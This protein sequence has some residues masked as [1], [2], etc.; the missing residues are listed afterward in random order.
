MLHRRTFLAAAAA[1]LAAPR[2]TFAAETVEALVVADVATRAILLRQGA[3]DR[4]FTP[5]STFK[6]PLALIG[7]D[8]GIL[9][10]AHHPAWEYRPELQAPERDRKTVDP[11]VWL[12]DSVVW[13]SQEITRKLG[14]EDFRRYVDLLG[15]GNRNLSG[16][17][18]LTR[19]WLDSSLAL[20]PE[21]QVGFVLGL[22][23]RDFPV[24]E[25]AYAMTGASMP[26]FEAEGGWTVRGK[27]GTAE[28]ND[29]DR[30]L[31]WFVGWA[32][33]GDRRLAFARLQVPNGRQEGFM[34]PRV[35]QAFLAELPGLAERWESR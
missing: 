13:Y 32:E 14:M 7:F 16:K 10:D 18:A 35:R 29:P 26:V 17:D 28:L 21:E 9:Q 34:G 27:T 1:L 2:A 33:R 25:H 6:V 8:S 12:R 30:D 15:Y 20:S 3:C 22:L 5:A 4:R 19:A 24:S 31:G 11:T 23:H